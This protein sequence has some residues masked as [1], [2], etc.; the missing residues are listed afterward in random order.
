MDN[1]I[2][3]VLILC[4]CNLIYIVSIITNVQ[5]YILLDQLQK[6]LFLVISHVPGGGGGG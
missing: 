2:L 5:N 6:T 4:G 3:T 1:Y